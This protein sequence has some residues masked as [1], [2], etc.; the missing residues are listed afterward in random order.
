MECFLIMTCKA[1]SIG[2]MYADEAFQKTRAIHSIIKLLKISNG[3]MSGKGRRTRRGSWGKT[4]NDIERQE[5][6]CLCLAIAKTHNWFE[7]FWAQGHYMLETGALATNQFNLDYLS[8]AYWILSQPPEAKGTAV[9]SYSIRFTSRPHWC[10]LV[11]HSASASLNILSNQFKLVI[12]IG[13]SKFNKQLPEH[14][15]L[16]F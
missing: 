9:L 4:I 16:C 13:V 12:V 1:L 2:N 7:T 3:W 5:Y 10:R 6:S 15:P 14:I 8:Q 11:V